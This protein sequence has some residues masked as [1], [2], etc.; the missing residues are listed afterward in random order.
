MSGIAAVVSVGRVAASVA[1]E[2][3][4]VVVVDCWAEGDCVICWVKGAC[5]FA[6]GMV[7]D[8][9]FPQASRNALKVMAPA[10]TAA[11]FRKSL[12]VSLPINYLLLSSKKPFRFD[13]TGFFSSLVHPH[14]FLWMYCFF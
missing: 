7:V 8:N 1:D 5:V 9:T 3:F 4:S 12:L 10:P 11:A 13:F 6:G 2:E 14:L